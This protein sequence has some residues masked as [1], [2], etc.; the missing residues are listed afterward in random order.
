MAS[1]DNEDGTIAANSVADDDDAVA[2]FAAGCS[3]VNCTATAATTT[4]KAIRAI[5]ADADLGIRLIR[6]SAATAA[7]KATERGVVRRRF[8]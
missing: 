8:V 3:C 4:A 5:F 7:A 6:R 1:V 2:A